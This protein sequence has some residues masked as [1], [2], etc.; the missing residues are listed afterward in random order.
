[1]KIGEI[2]DK[3]GINAKLI[4][5]YESIGLLSKAKRTDAGYRTYSEDDVQVLKFIKR[6]RNVGFSMNDIKKLLSLWKNKSRPS[7]DVKDLAS[8]HIQAMKDKADELQSMIKT[9]DYLVKNCHG[10]HRPTCPII[11]EFEKV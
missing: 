11:E 4:R 8:R 9:L 3:S 6:A 2:A 10:D 7:K 1:M 5:H